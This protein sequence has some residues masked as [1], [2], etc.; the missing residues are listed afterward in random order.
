MNNI[1]DTKAI[2]I[3]PRWPKNK[4]DIWN[5]LFEEA[6]GIVRRKTFVK[7][8]S[9]WLY[10]AILCVPAFVA[11][12]FYTVT[13]ETARGEHSVVRLPDHSTVTLNAESKISYKPYEW[14]ISRKVALEGE[15]CFDVKHGR[16]FSVQ[17]G[18]NCVNVLGTAFNVYARPGM[19]RVTCLAGRVKVSANRETV[20]LNP[21]M[22]ATC[23][24]GEWGISKETASYR[25][26]GWMLGKFT[27]VE[28]PLPEVVA[29]IER[30]YDI[31]ITSGAGL[32][33][34]Y[35]GHFSRTERP[36]DVL[37]I[38]GKPFGITFNIE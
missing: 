30:Q 33:H 19:Y 22:Q 5:D 28:T 10:A 1:M 11:I 35:T 29:E 15:A 23:R 20:V 9:P 2:K 4:D 31:R 6:D 26:A 8:I 16:R 12:H 25:E 18:R 21:G 14:F 32:N 38:I 3:R 34:L 7:R 13:E 17:S 27:F 24:E 37:E 36:E